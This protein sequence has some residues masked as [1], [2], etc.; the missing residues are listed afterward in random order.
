MKF[1]EYPLSP[2]IKQNIASAGFKRPTDIQYKA[3]PHI[4]R[5]EDV[6]AV[7]QTGTGK[8]AAFAIPVLQ[9][10]QNFKENQRRRDGIQC[11]V[12]VPTRELALQITKVF[13]SLATNTGVSVYG[14][15]GGVDQDP[16]IAKL[17]K[18]VDVLI[19]TPGRMFDLRHQ[20]ELRLERVRILIVDEADQMLGLGFVKDIRDVIKL[21]PRRRQTLFFS[22]T[23]DEDIKKL[24]YSLTPK[25]IRIQV[26]PKDPVS[27]NVEHHVLFVAMDDKRFFLERVLRENPEGKFLVFVRTKVR[28]ERVQKAMARVEINSLILHGDVEQNLRMETLQAFR[29]TEERLMIATDVSAR[30]IDV[31]AITHVINYD[32][33]TEADQYVHRIGRT[34]RGKAKGIAYSFCAPEEKELLQAIHRYTGYEISILN[35]D[36][37]AYRETLQQAEEDQF[38]L[39]ELMKEAEKATKRNKKKR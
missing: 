25:P 27:K 36:R 23:I 8:T 17:N 34:G 18:G 19:T 26:S 9:L 12:M 5:G 4:L 11:L 31:P 35:L 14:I 30:G 33:P 28:A 20:G 38:G 22:A 37:S 16:Q 1:S 15:F 2:Q 32:L 7:A 10:M 6:L 29:R 39:E 13:K 24:A 21:L 3:I